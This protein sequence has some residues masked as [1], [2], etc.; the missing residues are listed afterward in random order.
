MP[1]FPARSFAWPLTT[2][3]AVSV[4]TNWSGVIVLGSTPEPRS[5]SFASK[6][7]VVVVLSHPAALAAGLS[8][9]VTVGAMLS[10]LSET[11]DLVSAFPTLSIAKYSTVASPLLAASGTMTSPV[12]PGATLSGPPFTK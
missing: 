5:S 9:C 6:C 8:V 1:V 11:P 4:L 2:N 12:A 10:Y 3:P 7:T